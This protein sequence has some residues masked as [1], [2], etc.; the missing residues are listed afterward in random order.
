[1]LLLLYDVCLLQLNIV[2][3]IACPKTPS[4][5]NVI[6]LGYR[7]RLSKPPRRTHNKMRQAQRPDQE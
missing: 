6:T 2:L 1:M 3:V 5:R 7:R 4:K